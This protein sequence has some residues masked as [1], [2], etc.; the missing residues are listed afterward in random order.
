MMIEM[1][2]TQAR[3]LSES[4]LVFSF[5]L[6][7]SWIRYFTQYP[8]YRSPWFIPL[9]CRTRPIWIVA[10]RGGPGK[11]ALLGISMGIDE[12]GN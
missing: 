4:F 10:K 8:I 9:H 7:M 2:V 3:I 6:S 5:V 1:I 11:F 12:N